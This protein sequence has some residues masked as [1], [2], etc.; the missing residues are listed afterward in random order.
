MWLVLDDDSRF[1][2]EHVS[3]RYYLS[4]GALRIEIKDIFKEMI[5][6]EGIILWDN[7]CTIHYK[8]DISFFKVW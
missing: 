1:R 4:V 6:E 5:K 8:R 3:D 2:F 7:M